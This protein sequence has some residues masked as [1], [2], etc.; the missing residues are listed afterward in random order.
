MGA[1][2][3]AWWKRWKGKS[4]KV[5]PIIGELGAIARRS[6]PTEP[7]A[8]LREWASERGI[9]ADIISPKDARTLLTAVH[10]EA[11]SKRGHLLTGSTHGP[12]ANRPSLHSKYK[13]G[14]FLYK[15][16]I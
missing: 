2:L 1:A 4:N 3:D 10:V 5:N 8:D 6:E 12:N 9:E 16:A 11:S 7:S 14:R 15:D 13:L